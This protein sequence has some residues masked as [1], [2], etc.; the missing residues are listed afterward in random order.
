M[1]NDPQNLFNVLQL[2]GHPITE[3]WM[4]YMKRYCG[5]KKIC[6]PKDKEKRNRISSE[7]ITSRGKSNWYELSDKEKDELNKV[8]ERRCRMM[9]VAQE[10]TN[11][12]ELKERV[13]SVYL[14]RL[15]TDLSG[16]VTKHVHERFYDLTQ[17]QMEE[18]QRLMRI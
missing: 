7:F 11:L 8:I 6:H 4:G 3:D 5:A 9:T 14:R 17:E 18:Y 16:M 10:P 13:S 2:I 12:D 1:T 15:K